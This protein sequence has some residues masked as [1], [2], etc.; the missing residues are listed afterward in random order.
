MSSTYNVVVIGAGEINFGSPEGPWNHS[1]RLEHIFKDSTI[2]LRFLVLVDPSVER[3]VQRIRAKQA[4]VDIGCRSAWGPTAVCASIAEAASYL[5]TKGEQDVDLVILGCPPH[6]RGT[7]EQG[8]RAD[9]EML[10]HLPQARAYLVEKPVAAVNPFVDNDGDEVAR[11]FEATSSLCSVG[12]MLRYNKAILKIRETLK[13]NGLTPTCINARYFMAYEHARK[14]DWWNKSRSCGPVVEQA[15]HFID[16]IRFLAGEENEAL[17]DTV[18]ATTVTH[19]ETVGTLSKLG[20]DESVI[21]SEERV[22]R[23]TSAF[24]KHE[25]GTIG[26]LTHGITL[27]GTTYDTEI[28]V[29]ADGWIL[30]VRNAYDPVSTLAIRRPG[31]AEEEIIKIKDDP[32]LSEFEC[33]TRATQP[34]IAEMKGGEDVPTEPLSS[35]ADALKTY[36]LSWKIRLAAEE[37]AATSR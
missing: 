37:D 12:Y 20:F 18:K 3:A 33:L 9:V 8:K 4:S 13:V 19:N 14:L 25:K 30:R 31:Q 21:P 17:L 1:A 36:K 5:A 7:L 11:R 34:G 15:T 6:F 28:E 16:L 23:I 29:L 22:P 24:W 2:A 35:F 27:H 26:S 10:E 32:F